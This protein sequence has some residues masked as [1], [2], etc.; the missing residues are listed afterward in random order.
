MS[1]NIF[2]ALQLMGYGLGGVFATLAMFIVLIW[3]L[4]KVFPAKT[5]ENK[6]ED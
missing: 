2:K 6:Q 5:E 3:L 4:V 1:D